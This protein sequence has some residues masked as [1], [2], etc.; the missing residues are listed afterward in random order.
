MSDQNVKFKKPSEWI[1]KRAEEIE[2]D[3]VILY[4]LIYDRY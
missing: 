3:N 2:K 1:R 4:L